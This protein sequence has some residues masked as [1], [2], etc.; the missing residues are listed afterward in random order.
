MVAPPKVVGRKVRALQGSASRETRDTQLTG[1][2][3]RGVGLEPQ[4]R[5]LR[6]PKGAG[7]VKRGNLCAEQ[8]QTL[9]A[10]CRET[11]T[12]EPGPSAAADRER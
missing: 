10:P 1:Q 12:G 11:G 4:R 8:G 9:L 3:A 2:P 7:G 6:F 5:V